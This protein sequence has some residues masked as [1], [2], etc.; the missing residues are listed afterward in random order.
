MEKRWYCHHKFYETREDAL[1]VADVIDLDT[2]SL[3]WNG[4]MY[5]DTD[6]MKEYWPVYEEEIDD[7]GDM[8]QGDVIGFKLGY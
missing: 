8:V 5:Y 3:F 2:D 6:D 7:N 1:E 4:E